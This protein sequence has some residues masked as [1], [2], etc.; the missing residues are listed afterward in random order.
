MRVSDTAGRERLLELRVATGT[1]DQKLASGI[2]RI[3]QS[4]NNNDIYVAPRPVARA[5]KV[6]LHANGYCYCGL[7]K[8]YSESLLRD[9]H[10]VPPRR[11]FVA[12]QR[13]PTPDNN[14]LWAVEICFPPSPLFKPMDSIE[15]Y[16]ADRTASR[17]QSGCHI[18]RI[19]S[20]PEG[21]AVITPDVQELG[22]SRLS[23]GEYALCSLGPSISTM[24][25]SRRKFSNSFTRVPPKAI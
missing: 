6:S 10:Y 4:K 13:P 7:T 14:F 1:P 23:A 5:V 8:Q 20:L 2:W 9:G 19:L 17:W 24:R 16:V 3:W 21:K 11:E 12:W 18:S 25:Y 22:Y 15:K